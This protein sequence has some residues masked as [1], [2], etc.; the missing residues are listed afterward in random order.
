MV[1]ISGKHCVLDVSGKAIKR[2]Q[3]ARLYPI[4]IFVKLRD[5]GLLV[6][7]K[8]T[9]EQA[10]RAFEK[11]CRV[12][13]EFIEYFTAVVEG[14]NMEVI[15]KQVRQVIHNQTAT[16]TIWVPSNEGF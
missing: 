14:D 4:A 12:E 6:E 7:K 11:A 2:L 8:M 10:R 3:A 9:V 15:K 13:N 5:I 16:N 1:A